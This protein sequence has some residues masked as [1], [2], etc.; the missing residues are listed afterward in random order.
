MTAWWVPAA[1]G[2]AAMGLILATAWCVLRR[3]D[4]RNAGPEPEERARLH[5]QQLELEVLKDNFLANTSHELRTP[6]NGIIG[7]T[8]SLIEEAAGPLSPKVRDNLLLISGSSRRLLRLIN[9]IE[10]F[11]KLKRDEMTLEYEAVDLFQV[12][13][14]ALQL[15]EGL[16][17]DKPLA[18]IN[19]VDKTLPMA[20]ADSGKIEHIIY[21]LAGNAIKF[22]D[23]GHV[24]VAA[25][26]PSAGWLEVRVEDTGIG[27]VQEKID[28]IFEPFRQLEWHE[29]RQFDGAGI[30]L[31]ITKNVIELH[32]GRIW[33][34]SESGKGSAFI[35]TLP[36]A[37]TPERREGEA[38]SP[39]AESASPPV[40]MPPA[41]ADPDEAPC[42]VE[43]TTEIL[44]AAAGAAFD[45]V[46]QILAVD[47][48]FTNL[49]VIAN[50]LV[51]MGDIRLT[52]AH[53]GLECLELI[54][55]GFKPD[56]ILLDVMMPLVSGFEVCR[57]IRERY[58][59]AELPIIILTAKNQTTDLVKG[60]QAGANDYVTKPFIR[61]ELI[62]RINTHIRLVRTVHDLARTTAEREAVNR[63]LE[64]ARRIQMSVLPGKFPRDR[65]DF[66]LHAVM[67]PARM[68]GGDLYDFFFLDDRRLCLVVGDVS[69]KGVPAALFM[70]TAKALIKVLA[71]QPKYHDPAILMGELNRVLVRDNPR[72]MFVTLIIAV[73]HLDSG[74][75]VYANG[76]HDPP[77]LL[78]A[79]GGVRRTDSRDELVVGVRK[80]LAYHELTLFL[81]PGEGLFFY[82]DGIT[83]ARNKER[84]LFS[85]ERLEKELGRLASLPAE[86]IVDGVMAGVKAHTGDHPQW[87]DI[88][89][90]M[91]RYTGG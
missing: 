43:P 25:R 33:V 32:G 5:E 55:S 75:V 29:N 76:G 51:T 83:E 10:D 70:V 80:G 67:E 39:P 63:E 54:E 69:D 88:T 81:R 30:G 9:D 37:K 87:D 48:D 61:D 49:Q 31:A 12:T 79:D 19:A 26:Q 90:L 4:R 6:L 59:L 42:T 84:E 57:K 86:G 71:D 58:S 3:R 22:T 68:V 23:K 53:N 82:T 27:I 74:E 73:V 1:G 38:A 89:M 2:A 34:E 21:N 13:E 24:R 45:G 91:V 72:D 62:S 66:D 16:A 15:T 14:K 41:P 64:V 77:F 18:V 11:S 28:V 7:I 17:G 8:D 78:T 20:H 56:C 35:F 50:L 60:F 36:A 47:D 52:K 44:A 46:L 85:G 40:D 65:G